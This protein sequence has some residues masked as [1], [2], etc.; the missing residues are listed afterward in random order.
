MKS[1]LESFQ[2][3]ISLSEIF[4]FSERLR[5]PNLIKKNLE[6]IITQVSCQEL[7]HLK[8]F[9]VKLDFKR[10]IN[11]EKFLQNLQCKLDIFYDLF[12]LIKEI[13]IKELQNVIDK[14]NNSKEKKIFRKITCMVK[15]LME[16]NEIEIYIDDLNKV[17]EY[18]NYVFIGNTSSGKSTLINYL[19]GNKLEY[20]KDKDDFKNKI[21]IKETAG[22]MKGPAIGNAILESETDKIS[23]FISDERKQ[24]FWDL[25]GFKNGLI[26]RIKHVYQ[27]SELFKKI[28]RN[29]CVVLAIDQATFDTD[30]DDSLKI[31]IQQVYNLL[32]S[33]DLSSNNFII[34][35]T[36]VENFCCGISEDA[37][38][39]KTEQAKVNLRNTFKRLYESNKSQNYAEYFDL[40]SK[41]ETAI[42][43]FFKPNNVG[44]VTETILI[45]DRFD[46]S[47]TINNLKVNLSLE[48]ADKNDLRNLYKLMG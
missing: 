8:S 19:I 12:K 30:R 34:V 40:L 45:N 13:D 9:V 23:Y 25:P 26:K 10:R 43:F 3:S 35:Q 11:F 46:S 20:Y 22:Q 47:D 44:D 42:I 31:F 16:S 7:E 38:L 14:I 15:Y 32:S 36:K 21:R 37:I 5:W 28:N 2:I 29:F 6:S 24:I 18:K 41:N 17:K 1:I 33:N 4:E 48:P 27:L 39:V